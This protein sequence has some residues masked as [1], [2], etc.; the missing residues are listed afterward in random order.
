MRTAALGLLIGIAVAVIVAVP[1]QWD[2][3]VVAAAGV[4]SLLSSGGRMP[5]RG[6]VLLVGSVGAGLLALVGGLLTVLLS[7]PW[8]PG[9]V[10][11]ALAVLAL[12]LGALAAASHPVTAA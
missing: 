11:G 2:A 12:V 6:A 9:P 3:L 10:L 8:V 1:W 5:A 4:C 7:Q